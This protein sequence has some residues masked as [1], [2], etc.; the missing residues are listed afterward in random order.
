ML[1]VI[2]LSKSYNEKKTLLDILKVDNRF[3]IGLMPFMIF[4]RR[5][6]RNLYKA[7]LL[8][9]S[10][11]GA[12]KLIGVTDAHFQRLNYMDLVYHIRTT[13]TFKNM[14]FD[15]LYQIDMLKFELQNKYGDELKTD[16]DLIDAMDR[17][18]YLE[19][20]TIARHQRLI[21]K[22]KELLRKKQKILLIQK[23]IMLLQAVLP[24]F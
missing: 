3:K 6:V 13:S 12:R 2:N 1:E 19:S 11:I 16:P 9:N 21:Q 7:Y 10:L 15:N 23:L 20:R 4:K 22:E 14:T 5:M 24:A 18:N 17:I 8:N